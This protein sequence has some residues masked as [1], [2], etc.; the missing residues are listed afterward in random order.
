MRRRATWQQ[1][2]LYRRSS[3]KSK[4]RT[5]RL[6]SA[7]DDLA[8]HLGCGHQSPVCHV[9]AGPLTHR[10]QPR[11]SRLTE[12]P[13]RMAGPSTAQYLYAKGAQETKRRSASQVKARVALS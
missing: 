4:A 2:K 9:E 5:P 12:P 1:S 11:A 13:R 6:E 7:A 8:A 10:G 3:T